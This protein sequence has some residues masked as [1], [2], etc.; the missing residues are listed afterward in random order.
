[1]NPFKHDTKDN[2]TPLT[3]YK[4]HKGLQDY[5]SINFRQNLCTW[6]FKSLDTWDED[7]L[8]ADETQR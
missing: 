3:I 8:Q 1:M 2:N 7:E 5:R 6:S 4:T